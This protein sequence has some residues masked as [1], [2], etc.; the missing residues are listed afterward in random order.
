M[1]RTQDGAGRKTMRG[2][3]GACL[4]G[5]ATLAPSAAIAATQACA[6]LLDSRLQNIE[7]TSATEVVDTLPAADLVPARGQGAKSV[8][9]YLLNMPRF[10]R[11]MAKLTPVPKSDI[12]IELW[13]PKQW[14]GKLLG[15]GSHGFGGNFERGDMAMGLHR[16]YAVV[17]TDT[18]HSAGEEVA[19]KTVFNIGSAKFAVGNDVAVDD[20][21]WRAIHEMTVA[22]KQL[23]SLNYGTQ[24]KKAYFF[25]CSN[26]GRQAMREVQQFPADYDGVI[27]GSAAQDWTRSFATTLV[28]FQAG[29]LPSGAKM[30]PA[31]LSVARNAALATCDRLDGVA[32]GVLA[33][34]ERCRWDPRKI[35]CKAGSNQNDCLTGEEIAAISRV[36]EPLKDPA[37]GEMLYDGMVPGSEELWRN[38]FSFNPVTANFYR[39]MVVGDP[40]WSAEKAAKANV[41]E[42]LRKSEERNSPGNKINSINPDLST[43]R[44]HGGKLIQYHGW[45]DP[46]FA[47][48]FNPRY[49][50]EVIGLQPGPDRQARTQEFYRLF[51]APGMAHCHGGIGPVNFGGLDHHPLPTVDAD[52]DLLEAL[53]RWV[54]KGVAPERVIATQFTDSHKPQRQMPLCPYPKVATYVAGDVNQAASFACK[55]PPK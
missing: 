41:V 34:P 4:V 22:A 42:L 24:P 17:S 37:T 8:N 55:V 31:K 1:Y 10:C 46:S 11:V 51:M 53:D 9:A 29:T 2:I 48:G 28:Q 36:E 7:V 38:M 25:G 14:N 12:K 13:L 49:Y 27:S 52:H 15:I 30:S 33:D 3:L 50:S 40:S 20:F 45:N 54:E 26:G 43:F 35:E 16:G 47:P 18:G 32:D 23:V 44:D 21:A 6:G 5:F 19:G 39:Y